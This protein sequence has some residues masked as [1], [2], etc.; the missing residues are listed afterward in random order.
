[1]GWQAR[2]GF[3]EG[4]KRTIEWFGQQDEVWEAVYG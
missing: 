2:T 3:K 4:L 1:M